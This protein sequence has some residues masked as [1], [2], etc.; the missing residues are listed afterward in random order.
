MNITISIGRREAL[1]W[2][3]LA[4]CLA[5]IAYKFWPTTQNADAPRQAITSKTPVEP[6]PIDKATQAALEAL[7]DYT[8]EERIEFCQEA[9]V[10]RDGISSSA[11]RMG[12]LVE[13][14][15]DTPGTCSRVISDQSWSTL[16]HSA[17]VNMQPETQEM[18]LVADHLCEGDFKKESDS[19]L[20]VLR[21][22]GTLAGRRVE[23][24]CYI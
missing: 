23:D 11:T 6:A 16:T 3:A 15:R 1:L 12:E 21:E 9:S 22:L 14:C 7:G 19:A 2:V 8:E 13:V 20:S 10:A 5:I 18:F 24:R 17:C 4:I